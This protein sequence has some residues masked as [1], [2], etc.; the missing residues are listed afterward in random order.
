M[1]RHK[2][3]SGDVN[4]CIII[5]EINRLIINYIFFHIQ[6]LLRIQTTMLRQCCTMNLNIKKMKMLLSTFVWYGD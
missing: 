6:I 4:S 3:I 1:L 2:S 5:S